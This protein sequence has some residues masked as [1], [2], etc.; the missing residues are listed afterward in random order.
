[1]ILKRIEMRLF[2]CF[3]LSFY[4]G[5]AQTTIGLLYNDAAVAEGYTLFGYKENNDVYLINTCGE[6]VNHWLTNNKLGVLYLLENGTLLKSGANFLEIRDWDDNLLWEVDLTN[7]GLE[8]HHD[9]EPLPNGNILVLSRDFYSDSDAI[10]NG[11]DPLTVNTGL[12]SEKIVEIKPVGINSL[13]IEWEWK[14]WD[15][16]IQEYSAVQSNY[17]IIADHPELFDI[18]LGGAITDW[19]HA[20]GLDY[21][22]ILDQII[23]SSRRF[24]EIYI[25]DHSTTTLEA[26]SHSGGDSS[27][28]GDFLWRWG[29][30]ENYG[31]GTAADQK[32]FG[33]H[34]PKW[35]LPGYPNEG[36]LSVFNNG[37]GRTP[38]Y[39][40]IEIIDTEVDVNGNYSLS[41]SFLPT[42]TFW[43]W[44]GSVLG[45]VVLSNSQGGVN[46][47][48]N[49]NVLFCETIP[50]RVSEIDASGT[51]VWSYENPIG[52]GT[53]NQGDVIP[54]AYNQVFRA[55]KYP[56]N[57]IGF[58]G[59][60]LTPTGVL[61]NVN[62]VSDNCNLLN[63]LEVT[64][65]NASVVLYPNPVTEYFVIETNATIQSVV[66]YSV[67][68]KL[69]KEF[70][71][72]LERY[73][74]RN[75]FSGLY[76]VKISS[77]SGTIFKKI[78]KK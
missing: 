43:S 29:S 62:S 27:K 39:T 28:G 44:N 45:E 19:I 6:V 74:L 33:Q 30:P 76:F 46:V 36:K 41:G 72:G 57:Y 18:N 50:G 73:P 13:T 52:N 34:D 37:T 23:F 66:V 48:P 2:I 15:H 26:A 56:T 68:G 22:P 59:K 17:G 7:F 1:M 10:I 49:G 35:I 78:I 5:Q 25:I 67:N 64:P 75:L 69:V 20:N 42:D 31:Q 51:V 70:E 9:I 24:N 65:L 61:E 12:Y 60:N 3:L 4:F 14:L 38:L 55:E 32:L 21:N 16:T 40:S 53:Y 11:R 63:V 54:E 47:Q 77:N 71:G 8:Q 58:T